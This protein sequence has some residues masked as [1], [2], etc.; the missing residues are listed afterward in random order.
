MKK[1]IIL[2]VILSII[3]GLFCYMYFNNIS[4]S[5]IKN[6]F[7]KKSNSNTTSTTTETTSTV[8]AEKMTIQNTISKTGEILTDLEENI[9]LHASYYLKEV[10][11]EENQYV[12]QGENIIEYTNGT[13]LTAPYN[14]IITKINVPDDSKI[15]TTS[16]YITVESTDTL[17][18]S[19]SIDED[20]LSDIFAGQDVTLT[21]SALDNKEYSGHITNIGNVG[22]DGKFKVTAEFENDGYILL[23]MTGKFDV[24]LEKAEDIIAVPIEAVTK[25]NNQ[26]T[27]TKI[28]DDGTTEKINVTTGIKNDAYIE[29]KN[30]LSEGQ[31][32][33]YTQS[34]KNSSSNRKNMNFN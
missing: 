9:A 31:K 2:I 34:K 21:V 19:L 11:V 10:L 27:V 28:N 17:S 20:D 24:I 15:C 14:L 22:S 1:K 23:G 16:H 29:I 5:N 13:Y 26:S 30:G 32:V 7:S 4:F 6:M 12:E 33:Q 18:A 3:Y 25:E 8:T